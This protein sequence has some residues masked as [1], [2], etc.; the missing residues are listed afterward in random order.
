MWSRNR[1]PNTIGQFTSPS[2]LILMRPIET[3]ATFVTRRAFCVLCLRV[4]LEWWTD[5]PIH[6]AP[7][8]NNLV[9]PITEDSLYL[10]LY[11][12]NLVVNLFTIRNIS[13]II[14][15]TLRKLCIMVVSQFW[16][17]Y[18]YY[19]AHNSLKRNLSVF[20]YRDDLHKFF[21]KVS[22][23]LIGVFN[24]SYWL[25]QYELTTCI[26]VFHN[27]IESNRQKILTRVLFLFAYQCRSFLLLQTNSV[28]LSIYFTCARATL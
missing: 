17:F 23:F 26:C 22:E 14:Q 7:P 4:L 13:D 27:A 16:G 1:W 25:Q 3:M 12:P 11:K 21:Y 8:V 19:I 28:C 10:T 2:P 9:I 15:T 24:G 5:L 20:S 18:R 6:F